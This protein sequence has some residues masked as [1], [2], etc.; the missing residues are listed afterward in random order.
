VRSSALILA[1]LLFTGCASDGGSMGI[2]A[3]G[4]DST[5]SE[6]DVEAL[7]LFKISTENNHITIHSGGKVELKL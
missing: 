3:H 2:G 6:N 4:K 5:L 1:V 7:Y